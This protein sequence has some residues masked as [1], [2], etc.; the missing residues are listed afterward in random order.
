MA[1]SELC[2]SE[3]IGLLSCCDSRFLGDI[4]H[5]FARLIWAAA[6][7]TAAA[8]AG[9]A[10]AQDGASMVV[11]GTTIT[12]GGGA[13][14]LS[15]PDIDFTFVTNSQGNT[16]HKQTNSDLNDYG[17]IAVG[18]VETPLGYWGG[19][20]V[21]GIVSGFFANVSDSDHRKCDS[22]GCTVEDIVDNPNQSDSFGG[23][24]TTKATRDVDYWGAGAEARFGKGAEPVPDSGGY[25]FHMAYVGVG[26]DV[27]G[28]DQDNRLKVQGDIP[29]VKY[30]ET[31]DTTYWGG[32]LSVG[33]E[34]N[35]LGYLGIGSGWGLRSLLS[36][37][38]GV[39]DA[40]TDY[41][42][43]FTGGGANTRLGLSNDRVAFIG[44]AT[45]ETRKQLGARTSLSLVTDYE[46]YSYAPQMKY[47][48]AD[49]GACGGACSG[50]V[51]KTHISDDSAFE[52]RTTLRLNVALGAAP[53][54][55]S[56]P[57]SSQPLK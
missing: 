44:A 3:R 35:L 31:L 43:H 10:H 38:A 47:L 36:L 34:Y 50:K 46:Y 32:F 6:I 39:Y 20:P 13:Q 5:R 28:I 4:M 37:R 30:N 27:R 21:T 14:L 15:L 48:D 23:K 55:Y 2:T 42:G 40:Q 29:L 18:S 8:S 9:A 33:G 22:G 7:V 45:F 52:V 54:P 25:L 56:E 19:T 17:G 51:N 11:G 12:L 53:T 57:L 49:V 41:S 1:Q 16:V 24:F 26:T